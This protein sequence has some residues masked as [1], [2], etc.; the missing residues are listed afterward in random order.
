MAAF[1]YFLISCFIA[2]IIVASCFS[3]P[4]FGQYEDYE[5]CFDKS[6]PIS[7][8][9]AKC[10]IV[11]KLE[12][13]YESK[14]LDY[15]ERVSDLNTDQIYS[16]MRRMNKQRAEC[17]VAALVEFSV[18]RTD[19]SLDL[20]LRMQANLTV[21]DEE[22]IWLNELLFVEWPDGATPGSVT[23][24][25]EDEYFGTIGWKRPGP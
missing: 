14:I 3:S 5:P 21:S 20:L 15:Q 2:L 7:L 9:N 8:E 13:N 25:C 4:S 10:H 6:D 17:E 19:I 24:H 16:L 18:T 22:R 1:R 23:R 11:L 12:S